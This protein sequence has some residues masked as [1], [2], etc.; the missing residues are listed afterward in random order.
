MGDI[1]SAVAKIGFVGNV[2]HANKD[3]DRK[4]LPV[5]IS[6]DNFEEN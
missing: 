4:M 3:K 5:K 6:L 2:T 1:R